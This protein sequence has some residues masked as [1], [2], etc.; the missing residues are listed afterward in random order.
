MLRHIVLFKKKAELPQDAALEERV[1]I[2]LK[3]L[4]Q[5][6]DLIQSWRMSKNEL[7][8]PVCWDYVLESEFKTEED[9]KTYL[10]HPEHLKLMDD[11]KLYFDIAVVDY[12][13]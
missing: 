12:Y 10:I 8:R 9:L 11:I 1:Y 6:I 13:F 3:R 2:G 4:D 5:V 7:S